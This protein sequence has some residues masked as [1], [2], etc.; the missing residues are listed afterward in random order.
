MMC[1]MTYF[2]IS[3]LGTLRII[4]RDYFD[5]SETEIMWKGE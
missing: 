4:E 1:Q 2:P 3:K 5:Y